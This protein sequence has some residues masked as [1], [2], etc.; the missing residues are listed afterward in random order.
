MT[1]KY[2]KANWKTLKFLSTRKTAAEQR[3]KAYAE[4]L[5]RGVVSEIEYLDFE[6]KYDFLTMDYLQIEFSVSTVNTPFFKQKISTVDVATALREEDVQTL[7]GNLAAET[8]K[9]FRYQVTFQKLREESL[10]SWLKRY[11]GQ[12]YGLDLEKDEISFLSIPPCRQKRS[13]TATR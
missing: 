3:G 8:E 5:E 13:G 7:I 2:E 1:Q 10:N 12:D 4:A 6:K 11:D 9:D